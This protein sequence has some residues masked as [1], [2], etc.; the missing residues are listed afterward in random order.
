MYLLN[1]K[2]LFAL[3][4]AMHPDKALKTHQIALSQLLR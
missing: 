1:S 3:A 2:I 4:P